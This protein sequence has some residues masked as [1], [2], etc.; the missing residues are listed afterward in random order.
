M[1]LDNVLSVTWWWTVVH[2][3]EDTKLGLVATVQSLIGVASSPESLTPIVVVEAYNSKTMCN[4]QIWVTIKLL[5]KRK[6][7]TCLFTVLPTL[8]DKKLGLVAWVVEEE[9]WNNPESCEWWQDCKYFEG[10]ARTK[11]KNRWRLGL[12][13]IPVGFGFYS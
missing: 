13:G 8:E 6:N 4:Q 3:L 1:F 5:D 9:H 12:R 7:V 11:L 10:K 2:T